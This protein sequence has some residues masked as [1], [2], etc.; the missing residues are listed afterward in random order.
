VQLCFRLALGTPARL[1]PAWTRG[2]P[3]SGNDGVF[4]Y[5]GIVTIW[6]GFLV[7][8]W[9]RR[10]HASDA[11]LED[12]GYGQAQGYGE[13]GEPAADAS[14]AADEAEKLDSH[15][16]S[17]EYREHVPD[18]SEAESWPD[19]EPVARRSAAVRQPAAVGMSSAIG[20]SP[21]T[22][23]SQSRQQ[24]L[25]ARR[26]MLAI[27]VALSLITGGFM[28][29]GVVQWW[30]CVPP[31]GMLVFYVLLLREIAMADAERASKRTALAASQARAARHE[32][33]ARQRRHAQWA[34]AQPSAMIID[35][36][37]RVGDQLYD[38]Y[39]DAAVRAVGD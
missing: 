16:L 30:I 38:Q 19:T 33:V 27:L 5:I 17:P 13:L 21:G 34:A 10:P 20:S 24:M 31:I 23:P 35:I 26:R 29:L 36:S 25:R 28:V 39:A 6:A 37:G 12:D 22:A 1:V 14:E 7:P 2:G 8:A 3:V 15:P 11:D 9:L 18:Y 4:L 32:Q